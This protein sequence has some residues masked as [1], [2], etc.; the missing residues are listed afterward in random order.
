MT[1]YLVKLV[2]HTKSEQKWLEGLRVKIEG[3]FKECF[4]KTSDSVTVTWGLGS[5][6]DNL[7]LHFVSDVD[8]SYIEA[9]MKGKSLGNHI[10]GHTRTRG[11]MTG[12]EIY[13]YAGADRSQYTY[14]GY[15]KIALHEALHNLFPG[16][17]EAD[18]HGT[19]GGA[20]VASSPPKLPLTDKNK[21]LFRKGF[22]VKNGQLL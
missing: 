21:E 11:N 13:K 2:D 12:S 9:K 16:W 4:D 6:T 22:A 20:G 15:A 1:T 3:I 5:P 14:T 19:A 7:V 17:S 18:M 10:G 8:S